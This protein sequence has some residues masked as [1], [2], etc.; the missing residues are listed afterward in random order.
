MA[1]ETGIAWT[2]STRNLWAGCTKIGPGCDGCYAEAFQRWVQGKDPESG[3]AKNWGPGRPRVPY[4][5]GAF[6]DLRRWNTSAMIERGNNVAWRG[7]IGFWP[8]FLNTQSDFFDNDAPQAWRD[9]AYPVIEECHFLT[10][11]LVTKRI[12]NVPKMVP[13]HW[14]E[15]GFPPNVRLIITV[16]NQA[17]ADRDVP[18]LLALP[19]KNGISYEPA[20]EAVDWKKIECFPSGYYD[21]L[22]GVPVLVTGGIALRPSNVAGRN[23]EWI[24]VGGESD[25]AGHRARPF[26]IEWARATV[27]QCR[28]AGVPV[29]VKQLG[30]FCIGYAN[31]LRNPAL[32][33]D[34]PMWPADAGPI[35]HFK[36]RDDAGADPAEWPE[37][38][39][40]QE[41]PR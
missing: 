28:A 7:R 14:L 22:A 24:I 5:E 36:F 18:K 11:F 3:E 4:L 39:R 29:F 20:L 16:V 23:L 2:R 34:T 8:V 12:G 32:D 31:D 13:T 38:L 25:Q 10:F 30:S 15:R 35:A 37:D 21:A 19:C 40:V 26:D 17:E 33:S 9:A 6:K 1:K 27:Q 41:F